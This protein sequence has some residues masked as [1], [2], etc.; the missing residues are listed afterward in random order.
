MK[1]YISLGLADQDRV[2]AT[3]GVEEGELEV[4]PA[5]GAILQNSDH[6]VA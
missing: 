2:N 4:A 5:R 6:D 3:N 1:A